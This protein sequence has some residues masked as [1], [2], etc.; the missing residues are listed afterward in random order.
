MYNCQ[1]P[2]MPMPPVCSYK[3]LSMENFTY[4]IQESCVVGTKLSS[5]DITC[6]ER[7]WRWPKIDT[8]SPSSHNSNC[9]QSPYSLKKSPKKKKYTRSDAPF[10]T[11]TFQTMWTSTFSE[12]NPMCR[13]RI[14]SLCFWP[15]HFGIFYASPHFG[16]RTKGEVPPSPNSLGLN[17]DL[18]KN[19][20]GQGSCFKPAEV[21]FFEN[22]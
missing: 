3:L 1:T 18:N 17:W 16:P 5:R 7:I 15:L 22:L 2:C 8:F 20:Q 9:L 11:C 4:N 12:C 21:F 6:F 13:I 14:R 10:A 19:L